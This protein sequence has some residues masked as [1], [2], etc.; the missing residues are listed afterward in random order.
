MLPPGHLVRCPRFWPRAS[1]HIPQ[2]GYLI[3]GPNDILRVL[4]VGTTRTHDHGWLYCRRVAG[5]PDDD[6]PGRPPLHGW[7]PAWAVLRLRAPGPIW[8][9]ARDGWRYPLTAWLDYYGE[10]L[11]FRLWERAPW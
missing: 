6:H 10:A 9:I 7:I 3:P 8:R 4:Y 11:G 5:S 1:D 2:L